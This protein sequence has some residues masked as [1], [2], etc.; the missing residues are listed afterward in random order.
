MSKTGID[1]RKVVAELKRLRAKA[2]DITDRLTGQWA[3]N[4]IS[5]M[6]QEIVVPRD[7]GRLRDSQ[8]W[9]RV[10]NG[11]FR[12]FANTNYAAAVHA[13]RPWFSDIIARDAVKTLRTTVDRIKAEFERGGGDVGSS[14]NGTN[15]E[16]AARRGEATYRKEM[17]KRAKRKK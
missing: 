11:V 5:E 17:A 6:K 12:L 10:K 15:P 2:P 16:T 14:S 1:S 4:L 3:E 7:T 13:K 9:D 8:A